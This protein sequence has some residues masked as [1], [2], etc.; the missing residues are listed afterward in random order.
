MT[1]Q[2]TIVGGFARIVNLSARGT[3]PAARRA[4]GPGTHAAV[5]APDA[6]IAQA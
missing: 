2:R 6:P 3:V 5:P 4:V 1:V